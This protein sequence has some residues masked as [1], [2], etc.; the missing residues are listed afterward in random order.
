MNKKYVYSIFVVIS[1][2]L[3]SSFFQTTLSRF[4]KFNNSSASSTI[5]KSNSIS[6]VYVADCL[7][8]NEENLTED[9]TETFVQFLTKICFDYLNTKSNSLLSKSSKYAQFNNN[10]FNNVPIHLALGIFR[11]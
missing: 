7:M 5:S 6:G 9:S 2:L 8:E 10:I 11:I 1:L 4:Y 3:F